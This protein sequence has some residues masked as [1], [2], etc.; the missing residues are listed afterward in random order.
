MHIYIILD[1]ISPVSEPFNIKLDV[2]CLFFF[3]YSFPIM[4]I[5]NS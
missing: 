3:K 5:V 4:Y 2:L 1:T